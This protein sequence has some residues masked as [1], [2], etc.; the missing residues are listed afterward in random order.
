MIV[1]EGEKR[2]DRISE[3]RG[4]WELNGPLRE[5]ESDR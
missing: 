5:G 2:E 4:R 1:K 3:I